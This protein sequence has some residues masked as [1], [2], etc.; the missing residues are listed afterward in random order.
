MMRRADRR[1]AVRGLGIGLFL[2]VLALG[3]WEYDGRMKAEELRNR[4]QNEPIANVPRFSKIYLG[5]NG[6]PVRS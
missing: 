2:A 4:L 1:Y 6:G 5:T 3:G